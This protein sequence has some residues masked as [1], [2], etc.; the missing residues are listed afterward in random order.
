[1]NLTSIHED[2]GLIP[3]LAQWFNDLVLQTW[4]RSHVAVAMAQASSYSSDVTPSLGVDIEYIS[5]NK[6]NQDY[7]PQI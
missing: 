2:V 1:M 4:L 5:E 7:F 6:Y 3:S